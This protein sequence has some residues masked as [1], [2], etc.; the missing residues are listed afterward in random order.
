MERIEGLDSVGSTHNM[1]EFTA[2]PAF[3]LTG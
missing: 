2:N 3:L 1:H